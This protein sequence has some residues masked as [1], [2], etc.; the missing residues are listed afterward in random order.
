MNGVHNMKIKITTDSTCDLPAH[1][2]EELNISVLPITIV[3]GGAFF[4]DQVDITPQDIFDHVAAGGDI[5]TTAASNISEYMDF[6]ASFFPEYDALIHVN[7]GAQFSSCY[8]NARL[9]AGEMSNVYPLD[10]A[11][12]SS[13]QGVLVLEAHRLAQTATDPQVLW[14]ELNQVASRLESSFLVNQ[15]DYLVKGGRCP[16]IV[17]MGA[18]LLKLKPALVVSGGTIE[19]GKKYRG[20][21]EKCAQAYIKDI[22]KDSKNLGST[23]IIPTA[24]LSPEAI[25]QVT[26]WVEEYGSFT[27]IIQSIA[28]CAISCNCGPTTIGIMTLRNS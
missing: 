3:K 26:S 17:G 19:V 14:E 10:S 18:N 24:S 15:L 16:A 20:T 21:Y 5:C 23:V 8:Q 2:L 22:L 11:N 1:I 25:A 28:G 27:T 12:L 9:A 13:A 6:F 7:I 4:K